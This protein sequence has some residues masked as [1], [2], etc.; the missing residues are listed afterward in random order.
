MISKQ[1]A[2]HYTWGQNCDGWHLVKTDNL[3]VIQERMPPH[4][5]EVK[6]FHEKSNQFFYILS[7]E[8]AIEIEGKQ[9]IL[10][11]G[12]GIEIPCGTAHQMFNKSDDILEFIVVSCPPS[13]DDRVLVK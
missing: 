10:K 6:H 12:E 9:E 13:Q 11:A 2:E 7:G 1:T 5:S 4:T 3:S 8:A